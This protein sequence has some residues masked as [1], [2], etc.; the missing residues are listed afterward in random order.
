M[1]CNICGKSHDS[2]ACP[3]ELTK[4]WDQSMTPFCCPVCGGNGIR[5]QGFYTQTTGMW[6]SSGGTEQ[7]RSCTGTGVVWR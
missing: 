1:F 7:C 6:T 5:P 4:T 3:C 2:T